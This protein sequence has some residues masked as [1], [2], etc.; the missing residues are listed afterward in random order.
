MPSPQCTPPPFYL[1]DERGIRAG[2]RAL[3]RAFGWA[4]AFKEYFAVKATPNP[5]ILAILRAE[6]CGADA[7]SYP[8]LLLAARAGISGEAIMFTS[9]D[10]PAQ[11]F[12]KARELGAIINLDDITHLHYLEQH[13]GVPEMLK[14]P[15]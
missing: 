11:E 15:L 12:Q 8:E 5:S 6:G 14:L 2:A 7:S 9:N 4:P 1:Y 10:T 3:L 13:A